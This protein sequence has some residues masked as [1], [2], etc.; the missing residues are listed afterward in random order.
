[1]SEAKLTIKIENK[2]PVELNDFTDSFSSLGNQ[3]YKFLSENENFSLKPET[4]FNK[5]ISFTGVFK[6]VNSLVTTLIMILVPLLQVNLKKTDK[7]LKP[8]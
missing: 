8:I 4:K 2:R 5:R 6:Y 1:M 3:Y 7:T